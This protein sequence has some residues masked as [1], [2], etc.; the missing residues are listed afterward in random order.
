MKVVVTGATGNVGTALLRRLADEPDIEVHGVSRRPPGDAPPYRGVTWTPVDIGQ[1]GA[2]EPLA[3][4]FDK[5]DAVVH[6]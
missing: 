4:A 3:A 5:A 6:L 1:A 2:E